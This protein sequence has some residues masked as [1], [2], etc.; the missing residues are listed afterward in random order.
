MA[1]SKRIIKVV[2]EV[3]AV[4]DRIIERREKQPVHMGREL[5]YMS[6]GYY[7]ATPI[8]ASLFGGLW[9]DT[10]FDTKPNFVVI[11]LVVGTIAAFYNLYKILKN[12]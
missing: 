5:T 7:I 4:R 8:I 2:D 6:L 12:A 3:G 11:L 1:P 10:A 9:L